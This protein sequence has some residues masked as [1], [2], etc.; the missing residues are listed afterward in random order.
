MFITTKW[1]LLEFYPTVRQESK[2][3]EKN[4][5]NC[6]IWYTD[7]I[8]QFCSKTLYA[9]VMETEEE[10][11][12]HADKFETCRFKASLLKTPGV[13]NWQFL[14]TKGIRV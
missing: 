12:K 13:P 14:A 3:V 4:D 8:L 11:E 6:I 7:K 9:A 5:Y 2:L 1:D 10:G